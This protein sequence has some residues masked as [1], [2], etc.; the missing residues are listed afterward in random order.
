MSHRAVKIDVIVYLSNF[1]FSKLDFIFCGEYS[2]KLSV[3]HVPKCTQKVEKLF[4]LSNKRFGNWKH[5]LPVS[6][7]FHF[8]VRLQYLKSSQLFETMHLSLV[9]R[10]LIYYSSSFSYTIWSYPRVRTIIIRSIVNNTEGL[11]HIKYKNLSL[12]DINNSIRA[13]C[14]QYMEWAV[15]KSIPCSISSSVVILI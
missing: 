5:L 4:S 6:L 8:I 12:R 7:L 1:F 2:S 13:V 14:N 3:S 9:V 10:S 15:R 11:I